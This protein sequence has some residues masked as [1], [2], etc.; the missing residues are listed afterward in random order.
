MG[1]G[2]RR[3]SMKV[4]VLDFGV[5]KVNESSIN[6]HGEVIEREKSRLEERWTGS[7]RVRLATGK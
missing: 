4:I 3:V 5:S 1:P 7:I 6:W 2:L